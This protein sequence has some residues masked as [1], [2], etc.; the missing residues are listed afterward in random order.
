MTDGEE[1]SFIGA[2]PEN[3]CKEVLNEKWVLQKH[4]VCC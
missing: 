1:A 3:C 2:G 4:M